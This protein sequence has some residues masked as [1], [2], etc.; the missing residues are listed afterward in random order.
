MVE[1][2]TEMGIAAAGLWADEK[3]PPSQVPLQVPGPR[4]RSEA[5][6]NLLFPSV[7]PPA[8]GGDQAAVASW[9]SEFPS[10]QVA[11]CAAR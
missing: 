1:P 4:P 7:L 6:G 3:P 11:S 2:S 8:P 9:P 10:S 5:G